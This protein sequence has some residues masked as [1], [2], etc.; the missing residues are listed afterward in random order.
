MS[1]R[2]AIPLTPAP[3]PTLTGEMPFAVSVGDWAAGIWLFDAPV[4]AEVDTTVAE[5]GVGSVDDVRCIRRP[6]P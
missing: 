4:P 3:T 2:K 6:P 1:A 5:A